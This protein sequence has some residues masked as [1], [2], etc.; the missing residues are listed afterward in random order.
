VKLKIELSPAEARRGLLR[1]FRQGFTHMTCGQ[2]HM[3]TSDEALGHAKRAMPR[4]FQRCKKCQQNFPV[5]QFAFMVR[6]DAGGIY[7]E[8]MQRWEQFVKPNP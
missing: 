8:S 3:W 7:L 5:D 4:E 2:A 6:D 1:P